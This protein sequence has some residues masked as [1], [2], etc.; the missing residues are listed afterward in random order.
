MLGLVPDRFVGD[1]PVP[2]ADNVHADAAADPPLSFTTVF[3]NVNDGATSSFV[4]VQVAVPPGARPPTLEQP[5]DALI[6]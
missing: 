1:P 6:V 4:I 3:T 5:A 2:V